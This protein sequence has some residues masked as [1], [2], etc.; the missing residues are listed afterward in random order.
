MNGAI[1]D[2][3]RSQRLVERDF[4]TRFINSR[5]RKVGSLFHLSMNDMIRSRNILIPG[6]LVAWSGDL[7]SDFLGSQPVAVVVCVAGVEEDVDSLLDEGG[8]GGDG[9]FFTVVVA[10][11]GEG[12]ADG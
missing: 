12:V 7:G 10:G 5:K 11:G 6:F 3:Q 1:E 9:A 4:M 8:E 2:L